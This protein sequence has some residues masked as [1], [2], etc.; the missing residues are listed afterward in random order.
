MTKVGELLS[1]KGYVHPTSHSYTTDCVYKKFNPSDGKS[2]QNQQGYGVYQTV[3][4][5]VIDDG[6][7]TTIATI[8]KP[9][10]GGEKIQ[11]NPTDCDICG[12][13][14][15]SKCECDQY[16]ELMCEKGHMWWF[17]NNKRFY[18]D[19]HEQDDFDL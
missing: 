12:Y 19:P 16:S 15:I 8:D 2:Y 11:V 1:E 18:G 4:Q 13:K 7:G 3:D 14:A 9:N 6:T 5:N 10:K 17:S